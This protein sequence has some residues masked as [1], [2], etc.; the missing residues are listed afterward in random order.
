MKVPKEDLNFH[1]LGILS[2]S[3]EIGQKYLEDNL[4]V[5]DWGNII[6]DE[7]QGVL[8]KFGKIYKSNFFYELLTPLN[9]DSPIFNFLKKKINI[10]NHVAYSL[11][12]FDKNIEIIKNNGSM[13]ISKPVP[14]IAF[15][16]LRI[17]FLVNKLGFITEFIEEN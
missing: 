13:Q 8:I 17:V 1:H 16:N 2:E 11:K 3:M 7:R 15:N 5:V 9:E 6:E 12:N 4:G 14:A 10:M